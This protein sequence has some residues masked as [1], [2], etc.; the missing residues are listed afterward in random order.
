M[1][2]QA[3]SYTISPIAYIRTDL[4]TKFGCPRQSGLVNTL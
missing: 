3:H 1:A 2:K 4:P